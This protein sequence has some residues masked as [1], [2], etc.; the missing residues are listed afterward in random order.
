M[1]E[2]KD[3][4]RHR[5]SSAIAAF[6]KALDD[7]PGWREWNRGKF[8]HTLHFDEGW[9]TNDRPA[10]F[11][12]DDATDKQHA[13]I[14]RYFSLL[15]TPSE[16]RDLEFYFRRFPYAGTP[17]TRYAHL[18]NSCELYFG[19]F[20]QYK[21]RLKAVFDAVEAAV[22]GHGLAIGKFIKSFDKEFD[23]EIRE[24]H[25]IHHRERFE[26]IEIS[27]LFLIENV[28]LSNPKRAGMGW[29]K[30]QKRYYRLAGQVWGKRCLDQADRLDIFTEAVAEALLKVCP[31][32]KPGDV[33]APVAAPPSE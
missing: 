9:R 32:L 30:E 3:H 27:R 11:E 16:L 25:S 28:I 12:F 4:H 19:R 18:S 24:R 1:T 21:E 20:Y 15:Q 31:F 22:G 5:M 10:S 23:P 13:V 33:S 26:D 2:P 7:Y 14:M 8:G 29:D 17:I 6:V